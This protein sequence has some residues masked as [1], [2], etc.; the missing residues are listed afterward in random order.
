MS[1]SCKSCGNY[2]DCQGR[3]TAC[4]ISE[5]RRVAWI[6]KPSDVLEKEFDKFLKF[7]NHIDGLDKYTL[8]RLAF[9][10]GVKVGVGNK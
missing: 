6:P 5:R 9:K 8:M 4:K 1:K 7:V 2:V 3:D 10:A